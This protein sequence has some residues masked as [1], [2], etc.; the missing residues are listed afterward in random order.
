MEMVTNTS[1]IRALG[2]GNSAVQLHLSLAGPWEMSIV[3]HA[4]GFDPLRQTL[5]V[6]VQD[7]TASLMQVQRLTQKSPGSIVT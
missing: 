2:Q 6:Q 7:E 5:L 1:K 3:A 4:E